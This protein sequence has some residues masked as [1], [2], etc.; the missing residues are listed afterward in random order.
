MGL[1][2]ALVECDKTKSK[3][4][5]LVE[6]SCGSVTVAGHEKVVEL[7]SSPIPIYPWYQGTKRAPLLLQRQ[8]QSTTIVNFDSQFTI[9]MSHIKILFGTALWGPLPV[10]TIQEFMDVLRRWDV[11]DL[12]TAHLYVSADTQM[13]KPHLHIPLICNGDVG[14]ERTGTGRDRRTFV[15]HH[16]LQGSRICQRFRV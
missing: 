16:P 13:P 5:A 4:Y 3:T 9:I 1:L 10:E 15:V 6:I 2:W 8:C 11:R 7:Q 14:R 12:D